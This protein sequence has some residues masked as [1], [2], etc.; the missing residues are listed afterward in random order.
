MSLTTYT[1]TTTVQPATITQ[2]LQQHRPI[3]FPTSDEVIATPCPKIRQARYWILTIP[4]NDWNI[5][6]TLPANLSFLKGQKEEG[7]ASGYRHWQLVCAFKQKTSLHGVK[8]LF[9]PT[10]HAEPS[11]S[12]FANAYVWKDETRVEGTSFESNEQDQFIFTIE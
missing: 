3:D 5:P 4:E 6:E 12:E 8:K 10:A 11:R 9:G 7:A 1:P 2:P